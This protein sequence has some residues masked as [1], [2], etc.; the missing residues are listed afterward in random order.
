M[1]SSST[2]S[3]LALLLIAVLAAP[4]SA[5]ANPLR[6]GDGAGIPGGSERV[7]QLQQLFTALGYPLGRERGSGVFGVRTEG[8][9]RYF[10]SHHGLTPT[11]RANH[12]TLV[13]MRAQGAALATV[14]SAESEPVKGGVGAQLRARLPEVGALLLLLLIIALAAGPH[15]TGRA[16]RRARTAPR[17]ATLIGDATAFDPVTTGS[18]LGSV[19]VGAGALPPAAITSALTEQ[20]DAGGRIGEILHA[21]GVID[22]ST[23]RGA[24][25]AQLGLEPVGAGATG[26]PLLSRAYASSVGAVAL[27]DA[28]ADPPSDRSTPVAIAFTDPYPD[29]V[30][31]VESVIGRSVTPQVVDEPTFAVLLHDAYRDDAA[32]DIGQTL[33]RKANRG[34]SRGLLAGLAVLVAVA[35]VTLGAWVALVALTLVIATSQ[36]MRAAQA[37]HQGRASRAGRE[38]PE[39]RSETDPEL[40]RYTLVV[41][42]RGERRNTI[43]GCWAALEA[44][45]YPVAKLQG[46]AVIAE[47][48]TETLRAFHAVARPPWLQLLIAPADDGRAA[49]ALHGARNADGALTAMIDVRVPPRPDHLMQAATQ[50]ATVDNVAMSTTRSGS[51][52]VSVATLPRRWAR[53]SAATDHVVTAELHAAVGWEPHGSLTGPRRPIT[54]GDDPVWVCVPTY[55]EAEQV[56]QLCG[57]VLAELS[58]A[59]ID[60]HVL[61]IDDAS[62]DGT[63]EIAQRLADADPRM[64]VL[65]RAAKEGIGPAYMAGFRHA[66]D[67]GAAFVVEMDCDFS[68]DPAELPALLAATRDADLVLGSRYVAGGRVERW[69]I[70]RRVVSRTGCWYARKALDLPVRDLTGGFKCFHATVLDRLLREQ[71]QTSGYGFQVEMTY[72]AELAGF[73]IREVP[74]VFRDRTVGQSKMSLAIT[75]E[76]ARAVLRLRSARVTAARAPEHVTD[77]HELTAAAEAIA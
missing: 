35:L 3:A 64:H 25:A 8:A 33:A 41:P 61:V 9:V 22:A 53:R 26:V 42:L 29:V 38:D 49:L 74:I 31:R 15:V 43:R 57:A 34:R 66:L 11:G 1:S 48:D 5:A 58:A 60:G 65:H 73:R 62:P 68:H 30:R 7:L 36:F 39:L 63:G 56:E 71:I 40:P 45:R 44:L 6:K 76:A 46:L 50:L 12:R 13:L 70:V 28:Q 2:R 32:H 16:R 20:R 51:A 52:D 47:D 54:S 75:I 72:R 19:L 24:R 55:N 17:P 10:Q 14:A 77:Q 18:T 4:A 59:G 37:L 67:A 23:L 21:R 69:G 27:A